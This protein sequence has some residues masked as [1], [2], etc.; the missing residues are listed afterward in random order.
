MAPDDDTDFPE[1]SDAVRLTAEE[2]AFLLGDPDARA[3]QDERNARANRARTERRRADPSYAERLRAD[4]RERQRRRR[5]KAA[6]GRPEPEPAPAVPLP[7]LS[8]E[9]AAQRL[10]EHLRTAGTPQAAQLRNRPDALRR[11]VEG[12]VVYRT[13]AAN[14]ERPTR[15]AIAAA[16]RARF[17]VALTPSQIQKLRDHIEGFAHPGGPWHVNRGPISQGHVR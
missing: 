1:P 7:D 6:I 13:L 10:E 15:G 16:F 11:C 8:A 3:R 5:A 9:E 17:G 14:G 12:F 4:D 2:L